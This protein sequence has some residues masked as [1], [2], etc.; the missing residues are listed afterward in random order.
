MFRPA[1]T[2]PDGTLDEFKGPGG[3]FKIRSLGAIEVLGEMVYMH[4]VELRALPDNLG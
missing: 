3:K 4:V 2:H 1:N